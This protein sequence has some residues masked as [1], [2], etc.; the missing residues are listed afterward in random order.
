MRAVALAS[1]VLVAA[2]TPPPPEHVGAATPVLKDH[3]PFQADKKKFPRTELHS[4]YRRTQRDECGTRC[5]YRR[6][7]T[8]RLQFDL[9]DDKT[10]LVS[11][12]GVFREVF[13]SHANFT[14]QRLEWRRDWRGTWDGGDGHVTLELFP[15]DLA[16]RRTNEN[17]QADSPCKPMSLSL[18]CT[19]VEVALDAKPPTTEP[20][21]M[22]EATSEVEEQ[23]VTPFP[24]VFGMHRALVAKDGGSTQEPTRRYKLE[25]TYLEER[26]AQR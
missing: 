26:R 13:K 25:Q 14:E 1:L 8:G 11:D 16:C 6:D 21:W 18:D 15:Q 12:E 7:G 9:R 20:S 10:A 23:S 5:L 2:C 17:G 4:E 22:C 3:D 24:W 19:A